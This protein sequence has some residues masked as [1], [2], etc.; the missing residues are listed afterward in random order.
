MFYCP[1]S[2]KIAKKAF[3]RLAIPG[4]CRIFVL[5]KRKVRWPSGQAQVCKT[6]YSGSIPLRTS[7]KTCIPPLSLSIPS[8]HQP[9]GLSGLGAA[10]EVLEY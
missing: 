5:L 3:P 7:I 2:P 10:D 9:G 4:K 6:C 1:N 8:R